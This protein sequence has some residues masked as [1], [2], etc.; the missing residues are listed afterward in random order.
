MKEFA[1]GSLI[2]RY[3]LEDIDINEFKKIA[4]KIG[5]DRDGLG[6]AVAES[7]SKIVSLILSKMFNKTPWSVELQFKSWCTTPLSHPIYDDEIEKILADNF[8]FFKT[9]ET[10][11]FAPKKTSKA[12]VKRWLSDDYRGT[13]ENP[14]W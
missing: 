2:T 13:M 10:L 1:N 4:E 8:N 5:N 7:K 12:S 11:Y 9:S 6:A 3:E 14:N